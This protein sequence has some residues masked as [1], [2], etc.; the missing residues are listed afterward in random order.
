[1]LAYTLA[2]GVPD[3]CWF[4]S[5]L[6]CLPFQLS[7][8]EPG[9]AA[10]GSLNWGPATSGDTQLDVWVLSLSLAQL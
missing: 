9:E 2:A 4:A 6:V 3:V 5:G 8:D 1:M 10:E 7:A